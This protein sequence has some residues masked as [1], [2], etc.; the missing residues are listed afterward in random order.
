MECCKPRVPAGQPPHQLAERALPRE[1]PGTLVDRTAYLLRH[2]LEALLRARVRRADVRNLLSVAPRFWQDGA[3]PVCLVYHTD[4]DGDFGSFRLVIQGDGQQ[5]LQCMTCD[6]VVGGCWGAEI[7]V[8]NARGTNNAKE[9]LYVFGVQ[10]S[11]SALTDRI[12][13]GLL[14]AQDLVWAAQQQ[15]AAAQQQVAAQ[16]DEED[17]EHYELP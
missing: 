15:V 7:H 3:T 10:L 13:D 11:M 4:A 17:E 14:Q 16:D 9:Y 5:A 6:A 12:N 1:P 2:C 8:L